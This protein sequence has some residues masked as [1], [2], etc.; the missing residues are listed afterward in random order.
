MNIAVPLWMFLFV[1]FVVGLLFPKFP[2]A[3]DSFWLQ[4]LDRAIEDV[5]V[6]MLSVL[7]FALILSCAEK[8]N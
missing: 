8:P 3:G 2:P 4:R 5:F 6:V 1:V 7:L